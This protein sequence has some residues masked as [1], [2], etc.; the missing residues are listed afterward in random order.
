MSGTTSQLKPVPA[1]GLA[2]FFHRPLVWAAT[3]AAA[4]AIAVPL[5]LHQLDKNAQEKAVTVAPAAHSGGTPSQSDEALL[6]EISQTVSYSVPAPM[7][8]LADPT[9]NQTSS[10]QRKN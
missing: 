3:A 7:Q 5:T 8:P 4:L 2:G 6:E 9:A 1:R 10:T